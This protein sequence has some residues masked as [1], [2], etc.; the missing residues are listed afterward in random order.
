MR[1]ERINSTPINI[2]YKNIFLIKMLTREL[3]GFFY[4]LKHYRIFPIVIYLFDIVTIEM[5][6]IWRNCP[7]RKFRS[8]SLRLPKNSLF[9]FWQINVWEIS[10]YIHSPWKRHISYVVLLHDSQLRARFRSKMLFLLGR[11]CAFS[12]NEILSNV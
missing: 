8:V 3:F 12:I 5:V 6:L 9:L 10:S 11:S 1:W 7:K 4:S 2:Q